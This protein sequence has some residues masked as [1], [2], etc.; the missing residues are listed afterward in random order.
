MRVEAVDHTFPVEEQQPVLA[1]TTRGEEQQLK[2]AGGEHLMVIQACGD[3]PVTPCQM[4]RKIEHAIGAH[5]HPTPLS[6][7]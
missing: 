3:L 2:L 7:S 6:G 1:T 5:S 4:L